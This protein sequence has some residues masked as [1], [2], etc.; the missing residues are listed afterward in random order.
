M[1]DFGTTQAIVSLRTRADSRVA[2]HVR[3]GPRQ[4]VQILDID[5]RWVEI[6]HDGNQGWIRLEFII[7]E[8]P[9]PPGTWTMGLDVS[10]W[11]GNMNPL[12]AR[13][14]GIRFCVIKATD[15]N[16]SSGMPFTD[17]QFDRNAN[18]FPSLMLTTYYHFFRP[19]N[20]LTEQA[21]YFYD[22]IKHKNRQLPPVLDVERNSQRFSRSEMQSRVFRF[23]D[24]LSRRLRQDG[25]DDRIIIYTR[26]IFWN[27][28]VGSPGWLD[29]DKHFLWIARYSQTARHPWDDN[30]DLNIRPRPWSDYLFWQRSER[31]HGANFGASSRHID[32]N[33]YSGTSTELRNRFK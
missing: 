17:T 31:G 18:L 2:P 15:A 8:Q 27:D 22:R 12:R 11:Q 32:I 20:R 1:A 21:D 3:I 4:R 26:G 10:R 30:D 6:R 7:L 5:K 33:L 9:L 28:N 23:V 25:R 14:A 19:S 24:R 29:L 16:D 13:Q